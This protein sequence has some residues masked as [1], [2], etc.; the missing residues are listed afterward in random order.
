MTYNQQYL[1][2]A[3]AGGAALG[4]VFVTKQRAQSA[5]VGAIIGTIFG[6]FLIHNSKD[7]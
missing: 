1:A 5:I 2:S 3:A 7:S 4:L 6:A